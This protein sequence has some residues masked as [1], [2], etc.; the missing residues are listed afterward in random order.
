MRSS[1]YAAPPTKSGEVW[2]QE[3]YQYPIGT[4]V[5]GW[6]VGGLEHVL[7]FHILGI[8]IQIDFHIFRGVGIFKFLNKSVQVPKIRKVVLVNITLKCRPP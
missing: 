5:N 7:F 2:K 6:L 1:K 3:I 4:W 8:I